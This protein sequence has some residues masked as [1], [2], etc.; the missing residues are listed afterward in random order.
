MA[1]DSSLR[2]AVGGL[3]SGV[4]LQLRGMS[5]VKRG[6]SILDGALYLRESPRTP[7]WINGPCKDALRPRPEADG[8]L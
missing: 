6:G 4:D 5:Q 8:I 7:D 2:E 3:L 1:L